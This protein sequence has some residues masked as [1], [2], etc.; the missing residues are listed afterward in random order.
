MEK[1][2]F[3]MSIAETKIS[4]PHSGSGIQPGS[5]TGDTTVQMALHYIQ[6]LWL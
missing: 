1:V 3:F 2:Y 4:G 6:W 5:D